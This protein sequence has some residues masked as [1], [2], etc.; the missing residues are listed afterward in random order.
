ME[1]ILYGDGYND[2]VA[3]ISRFGVSWTTSLGLSSP[4]SA[5]KNF[6]FRYGSNNN[7]IW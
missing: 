5:L 6:W 4:V 7:N 2:I 3:P 1:I